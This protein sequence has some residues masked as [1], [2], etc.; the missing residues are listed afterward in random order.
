MGDTGATNYYSA[1]P[2]ERRDWCD[3]FV[4]AYNAKSHEEERH[5]DARMELLVLFFSRIDCLA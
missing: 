3:E 4:K 2:E 1:N 5:T